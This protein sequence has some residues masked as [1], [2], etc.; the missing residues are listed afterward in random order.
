MKLTLTKQEGELLLDMMEDAI[1]DAETNMKNSSRDDRERLW[2]RYQSYLA[3][4]EVV[5]EQIYGKA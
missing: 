3:L 1:N 5:Q 4:D 2:D